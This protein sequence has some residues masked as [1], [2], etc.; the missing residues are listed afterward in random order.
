[1]KKSKRQFRSKK[2]RKL[3]MSEVMTMKRLG[4]KPCEYIVQL[5]RAWQEDQYFYMQINLA[6]RGTVKDLLLDLA[7][8][9][10]GYWH[11][12]PPLPLVLLLMLLLLLLLLLMLL[13]SSSPSSHHHPHHPLSSYLIQVYRR[14]LSGASCTTWQRDSTTSTDAVSCIWT[15]SRPIYSY[16][17]QVQ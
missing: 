4:Q 13:S 1:M 10:T 3:L 6:E 11:P 14:T 7:T 5:I 12:L 2:D 9:G 16:H 15:S 17:K 8:K